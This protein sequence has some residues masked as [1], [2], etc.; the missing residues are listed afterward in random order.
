M[1]VRRLKVSLPEGLHVGPGYL[2]CRLARRWP[3]RI[4]LS[5]RHGTYNAK[6]VLELL[7]AG[8]GP[9]AEVELQ[10]DG[11][12]ESEAGEILAAF[13]ISSDYTS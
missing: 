8:L 3:C 11:A 2:F 10:C 13:L 1:F 12:G 9:G 5:T 7:Q 4:T 6:S